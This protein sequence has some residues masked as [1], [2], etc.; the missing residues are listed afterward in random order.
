MQITMRHDARLLSRWQM[1]ECAIVVHVEVAYLAFQQRVW[2]PRDLSDDQAS[3]VEFIAGPVELCGSK[4]GDVIVVEGEFAMPPFGV[5]KS[6]ADQPPIELL[7]HCRYVVV[8]QAGRQGT[9]DAHLKI[10]AR[11]KFRRP[12][13]M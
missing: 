13:P 11:H 4:R 10:S 5:V 9:F 6:V 3:W 8:G 2:R 7:P 12:L 1:R